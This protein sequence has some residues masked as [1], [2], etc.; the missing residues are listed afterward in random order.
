MD[1]ARGG[2]SDIINP[3][4]AR[5]LSDR[6]ADTRKRGANEVE[7]LVRQVCASKDWRQVHSLISTLQAQ[8]TRSAQPSA[9]KGGLIALSAVA[10]AAEANVKDFVPELIRPVLELFRDTDASVRYHAAESLYNIAKVART[11]MLPCFADVVVGMCRLMADPDRQVL[12]AARALETLV[13]DVAS[14]GHLDVEILVRTFKQQLRLTDSPFVRQLILTWLSALDGDPKVSIV[15]HLPDVLGGV[16]GTLS[17]ANKIVVQSAEQVLKSLLKK[18]Q[19]RCAEGKPVEWGPVLAILIDFCAARDER[20]KET[21]LHWVI[22]VLELGK[23]NMMPH[24]ADLLTAV[25][26]CVSDREDRI[27]AVAHEANDKLTRLVQS[28]Q[29]GEAEV[30]L[31]ELRALLPLLLD[32]L[33]TALG[34]TENATRCASLQWLHTLLECNPAFVEK[35]FQRL[36]PELMKLLSDP[37]DKVVQMDLAVLAM[38]TKEPSDGEKKNFKRFL[39][40]IIELLQ[41]EDHK[42]MPRA[43]MIV[44]TLANTSVST[45]EVFRNIADILPSQKDLA[46]VSALVTTL[47]MI[48]LTSPELQPLRTVLK[49]GLEDAE[50]R[51]LFTALYKC[52]CFNAV[53]VVSL[54]LLTKAYEHAYMLIKSFG[55]REITVSMMLQVDKLVQLIESPVFTSLR[56]A[57][58]EPTENPYLVKALFGIL[59]LL[60]QSSTFEDLHKRLKSVN[61]LCNLHSSVDTMRDPGSR[62]GVDWSLLLKHFRTVEDQKEDYFKVARQDRR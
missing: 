36:F 29:Q 6:A 12:R 61:T 58:L 8:F 41:R 22:E 14:E 1:A 38:I 46:F 54:C 10:V 39:T 9:R 19:Q 24:V 32:A 13:K 3:A 25:L 5:T 15:C 18:L 7:S 11:N 35:C 48:L 60:P 55:E 16:L 37:N 53:S 40:E 2:S 20:A 43:A 59:M 30:S 62:G 57:L 33:T 17:D 4:L 44:K 27:R 42:L 28:A 31:D 47:N 26:P 52:W 34:N 50:A 56:V 45:D 23:Q 21:A 51:S 49:R